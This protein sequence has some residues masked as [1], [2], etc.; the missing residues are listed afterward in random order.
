[1]S[2]N[3]TEFPSVEQRTKDLE[4]TYPTGFALLP[5]NF[6]SA[7]TVADFRNVAE[8]ATVKTLLRSAGLPHEDIVERAARPPYLQNNDNEWMAP[9]LF[10]SGL[11]MSESPHLVAIALGAIANYL[12]DFFRGLTGE[13]SVKMNIVVENPID[14]SCKK[15]TYEGPPEGLKELPEIIRSTTDD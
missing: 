2:T 9:T 5:I 4:C 1:M 7:G 10:I 13:K 8:A 6:E 14:R 11:I 15:V 3:I 12:T